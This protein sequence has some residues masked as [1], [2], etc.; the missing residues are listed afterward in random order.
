MATIF[1][2]SK[3]VWERCDYSVPTCTT[4]IYGN[5]VPVQGCL[6]ERRSH[7]FPPH[8]TTACRSICVR[9]ILLFVQPNG[10]KE[11]CRVLRHCSHIERLGQPLREID[12]RTGECTQTFCGDVALCT[13]ANTTIEELDLSWNCFRSRSAV[14]LIKGLEVT[15]CTRHFSV[16]CRRRRDSIL[17]YVGYK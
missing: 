16:T 7:A 9:G 6:R 1:S 10:V 15:D 3:Y 2:I 12:N 4:G 17:F 11:R 14:A 13:A 8:Y 5:A